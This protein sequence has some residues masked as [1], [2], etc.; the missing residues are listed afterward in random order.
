MVGRVLEDSTKCLSNQ[1]RHSEL[2]P[3]RLGAEAHKANGKG[4]KHSDGPAMRNAILGGSV[5]LDGS[6]DERF[7]DEESKADGKISWQ[8]TE[9]CRANTGR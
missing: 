6:A 3:K 9:T 2:R 1:K 7:K 5:R 4:S 8:V